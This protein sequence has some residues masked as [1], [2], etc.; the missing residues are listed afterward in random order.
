M[1]LVKVSTGLV[2]TSLVGVGTLL[3]S[4]IS[5]VQACGFHTTHSTPETT[6]FQT[7]TTS[8]TTA[9]ASF[10][11]PN[12]PLPNVL[13]LGG[14]LFIAGTTVAIFYHKRQKSQASPSAPLT[15]SDAL[16]SETPINGETAA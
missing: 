16:P 11:V 8:S 5:S 3:A 10:Q 1:G 6:H 12:A 7:G 14:G 9:D 4:S 2:V 13:A 15:P